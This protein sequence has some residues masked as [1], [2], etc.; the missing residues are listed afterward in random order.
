[1]KR[2][3]HILAA[4]AV[5]VA[6]A[7]AL[8]ADTLFVEPAIKSVTIFGDQAKI[9]REIDCRLGSGI[10]PVLMS[11]LPMG[12][13]AGSARAGLVNGEAT[14][15]RLVER[16]RTESVS[17][18]DR[19][20]AL[21]TQIDS[22]KY[23]H[24]D[25]INDLIGVLEQQRQLLL[26]ASSSGNSEM[27]RRTREGSFDVASWKSAYSFLGASL[28]QL[29]DSLRV[30]KNTAAAFEAKLSSLESRKSELNSLEGKT[31]KV[32]TVDIESPR[33]GN[34]TLYLEYMIGGAAWRP[35][36]DFRLLSYDTL[37]L[38]YYGEVSQRTGE[39]WR[40]VELTLSTSRPRFASSPGDFAPRYVVA[41]AERDLLAEGRSNSIRQ[42]VTAGIE[43]MPVLTDELSRMGEIHIRGGRGNSIKYDADGIATSIFS[44][45]SQFA[46]S[47]EIK[48]PQTVLAGSE[49]VRAPIATFRM[50]CDLKLV[51]R[52]SNQEAVF[53]FV[54]LT[55]DED[56]PLLP[57]TV[58]LFGDAD[59]LGVAGL[60]DIVFPN[61]EF[62]VP[63]GA[64]ESIQLKR[65]ITF[66]EHEK[67]GDTWKAKQRIS[68]RVTNNGAMSRTVR[69][70]EAVPVS[71][72][73]E[74]KIEFE[75]LVPEPAD[76]NLNGMAVWELEVS[77]G[78]TRTVEFSYKI[79]YPANTT[80]RGL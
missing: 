73:K 80:L 50:P 62:E 35:I 34:V 54:E 17:V 7:K 2:L 47:F 61:Q 21:E 1:M 65:E 37:E 36:Y 60:S 22:I 29:S 67:K 63:F 26:M 38:R 76:K 20:A 28:T 32:V 59:Y 48:Y 6:S 40:N 30:L 14:V 77:A 72:N 53:R 45:S 31:S 13:T 33:A 23:Y 55:N 56:V 52:P 70:E 75:K 8:G 15:V 71:Q 64:D 49:S 44:S 46:T 51:A 19:V 18:N 78:E 69:L 25:R 27:E 24:Y 68:L 11:G 41:A 74:I 16:T 4:L 43:N 39:D 5:V 3:M 10:V 66:V 12:M 79:E 58:H 57:G 9:R 42:I